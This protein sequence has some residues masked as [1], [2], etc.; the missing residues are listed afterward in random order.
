MLP[1]LQEILNLPAFRKAEVLCGFS[2]L[3]QVVTWVHVSEVMDAH[4]FLSGGEVL[5]T[6]GVE[7]ARARPAEQAHFITSLAQGGAH[8]LIIELVQWMQEVSPEILAAARLYDFPLMVFR[9]EVRY[10]DLTRAA[11]QR[12]LQPH[13]ESVLGGNPIIEALVETGRHTQFL[14]DQ[15]GP[16][17][18]L[19]SR[20]R[21]SLLSTL[22][23]LLG[24]QFNIAEAAR[25]LGVRRQTIYYR[26][27]QLRGMLGDLDSPKRQLYLQVALELLVL[28]PT[29]FDTLSLVRTEP[30]KIP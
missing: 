8:G 5:L 28:E 4:R 11:H 9:E 19:P 23:T 21:S 3:S 14:A 16:I 30:K 6:T 25:V 1:T 12:I 20:P 24:H 29:D 18:S 13:S 17:L 22:Q 27:E 2:Q 7:L 26:L 15:L 10:A